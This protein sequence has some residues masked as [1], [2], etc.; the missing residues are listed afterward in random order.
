MVRRTL[1]AYGHWDVL[2]NN[3]AVAITK[4]FQIIEADFD[5]SFA[6]TSRASFQAGWI[7]AQNSRVSGGHRLI[8][9]RRPAPVSAPAALTSGQL[10][11]AGP[12]SA[13]SITSAS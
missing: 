7:T 6:G 3:A 11:A 9:A 12:G 2:V 13:R 1:A 8:G 10:Q 4:P 5:L